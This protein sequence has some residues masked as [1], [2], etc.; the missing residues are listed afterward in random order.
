M[1]PRP[2]ATP[3]RELATAF[4]SSAQEMRNGVALSLMRW[5][6]FLRGFLLALVFLGLLRCFGRVHAA[7]WAWAR[8][9]RLQRRVVHLEARYFANWSRW[10]S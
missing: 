4:P 1:A 5:P 7:S 2:D 9:E 10:A 8:I 6:R 3:C